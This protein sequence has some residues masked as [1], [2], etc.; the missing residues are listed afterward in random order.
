MKGKISHRHLTVASFFYSFF[1]LC[2][3]NNYVIYGEEWVLGQEYVL[4]FTF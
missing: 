3:I 2:Q 1:N 4:L